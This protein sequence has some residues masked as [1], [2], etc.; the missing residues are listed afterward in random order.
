MEV[1]RR[2][3]GAHRLLRIVVRPLQGAGSGAGRA[4]GRIRRPDLHLQG[5][6]RRGAGARRGVRHPFDPH[7]AVRPD[8]RQAPDGAGRNAQGVAQGGHRQGTA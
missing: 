4:G 1:P 5:Q 3:T 2:Q 7:A 8:E 6:H